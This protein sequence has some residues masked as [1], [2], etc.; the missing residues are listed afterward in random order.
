VVEIRNCID[1]LS[2]KKAGTRLETVVL[3]F[4]ADM[5]VSS[6]IASSLEEGERKAAEALSSGK[7]AEIFG[8]MVHM[9]GGPADLLGRPDSYLPL[10][11]CLRP[12]VATHGGWLSRCDARG[13]G[14]AVIDLGGGRRHPDDRIDHRVGFSELLPLG[15][16]V[17]RGDMIGLV[18][19]ANE[20]SAD[21]AA[22]ALQANYRIADHAPSLPAVISARL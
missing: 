2:G 20:A 7:A 10:A 5:L 3:A 17:E 12:V 19:A 1:F 11:P 13:I 22:A 6:G 14:M 9:L 21:A 4:A 15:T 16:R 18:H 8:R